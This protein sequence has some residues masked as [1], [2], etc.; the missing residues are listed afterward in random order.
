MCPSISKKRRRRLLNWSLPGLV[1]RREFEQATHPHTSIRDDGKDGASGAPVRGHG[2]G[3]W[4]IPAFDSPALS[5]TA[6]LLGFARHLHERGQE[7]PGS[8][9]PPRDHHPNVSVLPTENRFSKWCWQPSSCSTQFLLDK[10]CVTRGGR[11]MSDS[12]SFETVEMSSV[13]LVHKCYLR[14]IIPLFKIRCKFCE[15]SMPEPPSSSSG[16]QEVFHGDP[17]P[18]KACGE[19]GSGAN[20]H[21]NTSHQL[22]TCASGSSEI[23]RALDTGPCG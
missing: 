10:N 17:S 14:R 23:I 15:E 16:D 12:F 2:R 13:A 6:G 5:R 8:T 22:S 4:S 3:L 19:G 7:P 18:Q 21:R 20:Y 9:I 11:E 1:H